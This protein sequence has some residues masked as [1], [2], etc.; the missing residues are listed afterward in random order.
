MP[1]LGCAAARTGRG[2]QVVAVD[3]EHLLM[4][5]GEDAGGEQAGDAPAQ[6]DGALAAV[7][8]G[9]RWCGD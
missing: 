3:D 5:L 6:Y 2:G 8:T 7:T 9:C 1:D 4:A